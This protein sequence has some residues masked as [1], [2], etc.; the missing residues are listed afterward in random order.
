MN[1]TKHVISYEEIRVKF[2]SHVSHFLPYFKTNLSYYCC[3]CCNASSVSVAVLTSALLLGH[4]VETQVMPCQHMTADQEDGR[5]ATVFCSINFDFTT[6]SR[7]SRRRKP[8]DLATLLSL[9]GPDTTYYRSV[10]LLLNKS[11]GT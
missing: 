7:T 3:L 1:I 5:P 11:K 8:G 10:I 6:N 4:E 9:V 2:S